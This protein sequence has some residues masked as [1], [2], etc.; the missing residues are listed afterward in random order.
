[1]VNGLWW[2]GWSIPVIYSSL[3]YMEV[4]PWKIHL[5]ACNQFCN[6]NPHKKTTILLLVLR[7]A[8][9][10]LAGTSVKSSSFF[11]IAIYLSLLG[12]SH[13][14]LQP[15]Q[16]CPSNHQLLWDKSVLCSPTSWWVVSG[17]FWQSLGHIGHKQAY[18]SAMKSENMFFLSD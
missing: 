12:F 3:S 13:T 7:P 11:P 8:L 5:G 14:G 17:V 6:K 15:S 4:L 2:K 10:C 18:V 16:Q 9:Y 1:M